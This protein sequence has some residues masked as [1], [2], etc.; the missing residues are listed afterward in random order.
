MA[1]AIPPTERRALSLRGRQTRTRSRDRRNDG[2]IYSGRTS[3]RLRAITSFSRFNH[4][5]IDKILR[6]IPPL[7]VNLAIQRTIGMTLFTQ[8][9]LLQILDFLQIKGRLVIPA[10]WPQ[11]SS[12]VEF[13]S[14]QYVIGGNQVRIDVRGHRDKRPTQPPKICYQRT[15]CVVVWS[16]AHAGRDCHPSVAAVATLPS[17]PASPA[18]V[19]VPQHRSHERT[20]S[21]TSEPNLRPPR[22]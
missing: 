3:S 7:A 13:G 10:S 2:W 18:D 1:Q 12:K 11:L 15:T 19:F 6:A 9:Q 8:D 22:W 20:S 21:S 4:S 5:S 14:S 16:S 17:W